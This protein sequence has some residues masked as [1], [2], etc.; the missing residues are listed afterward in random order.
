MTG[1]LIYKCR[2]CDRIHVSARVPRLA[3]YLA[4]MLLY[5]RTPDDFKGPP[6]QQTTLQNMVSNTETVSNS[7]IASQ[8]LALQTSLQASYE[9]TS[10]LSQLTLTKFLPAGG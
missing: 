6:Q 5:G 7:Q 9:A 10:I 1:Q 3:T 8:L 4:H 2:L